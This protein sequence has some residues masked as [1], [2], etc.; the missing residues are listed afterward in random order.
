MVYEIRGE[1][2]LSQT[3][4]RTMKQRCIEVILRAACIETIREDVIRPVLEYYS[5]K[6]PPCKL[7]DDAVLLAWQLLRQGTMMCYLLNYFRSGI[8]ES[9][10]P[11][12]RPVDEKAFSDD[13]ARENIRMFLLAC[14]NTLFMTEDQLFEPTSL[15]E[16]NTNTLSRALSMTDSFFT[17]I[18]RIQGLDYT[19]QTAETCESDP[20]FYIENT[21]EDVEGGADM[22]LMALGELLR[23]EQQYVADLDAL[24]G[25]AEELRID[26]I[27]P[28]K[29]HSGIFA[30]L[31]EMVDFQRRFLLKM[32][33]KL[34]NTVLSDAT[35][36]YKC[37]IGSLFAEDEEGFV[38]YET[39][40]A[41]QSLAQ[42]LITQETINLEK[43]S[44]ILSPS[45][46]LRSYMI[47][48]LQRICRYPLLLDNILKKSP[49]DAPDQ[50][51]L[52]QAKN[53]TLRIANRV[54]ECK[55]EEENKLAVKEL[56]MM[57]KDWDGIDKENL[58]KLLIKDSAELLPKGDI[59]LYLFE[60]CLLITMSGRNRVEIKAIVATSRMLA[61]ADDKR[62]RCFSI[63]YQGR[64]APL[65]FRLPNDER[66]IQWQSYLA[67]MIAKNQPK[68]EK[69]LAS[70]KIILRLK[71]HYDKDIFV[72]A[73]RRE[74]DTI[75]ELKETIISKLQVAMRL[76]ARPMTITANEMTLKYYDA[77]RDLISMLDDEDLKVALTFSPQSLNI[78]VSS[79]PSSPSSLMAH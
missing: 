29:V 8:L 38:V 3:T 47:K 70:Q 45:V 5:S 43:K 72:A 67:R 22:R 58:G 32:E 79:S 39:F 78:Q 48:P 20:L 62:G 7:K 76:L 41:N 52:K 26:Q 19:K 73:V 60:K 4:V 50:E 63:R 37:G 74:L 55:R 61:L 69:Q 40:C 9:F 46:Q 44:N 64:D 59:V 71:I 77:D 11:L 68:T 10:H 54:N 1:Q 2:P 28:K 15:Y 27:I 14:K 16:D 18:A 65:T 23:T 36:S 42:E 57:V 12:K 75:V 6:D 53:I 49:A 30:N 56:F 17:R 33:A 31:D 66:F 34:T 13:L 21:K 25:F 24:Q 51:E 35:A